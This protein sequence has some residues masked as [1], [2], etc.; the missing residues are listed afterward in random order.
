MLAWMDRNAHSPCSQSLIP[1]QIL[2]LHSPPNRL[3]VRRSSHHRAH[4]ACASPSASHTMATL[5]APVVPKFTLP[6]VVEP[7]KPTPTP[8]AA[9][10]AVD[11]RCVHHGPRAFGSAGSAAEAGFLRAHSHA[12][13]VWRSLRALRGSVALAV[14]R[15]CSAEC[16]GARRSANGL[17]VTSI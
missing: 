15:G 3:T 4:S 12:R 9:V 16:V 10:E 8:P 5:N 13:G 7:P 14:G 11:E 6:P 17:H 2:H 1:Y